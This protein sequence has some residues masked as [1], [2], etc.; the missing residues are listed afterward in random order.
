MSAGVRRRYGLSDYLNRRVL[1]MLGLGFSSGLPFLLVANTFGYW[2]RDEGVSLTRIG[3]IS[4]VGLAYS[5]KFLWAP[6]LDRLSAPGLGRLGL[7]RGWMAL[8]Q[9]VPS[10]SVFGAAGW[11]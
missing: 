10:A 1:I 4:W 3:F 11:H 9:I 8:M 6:L 2:L 7:R 5:F